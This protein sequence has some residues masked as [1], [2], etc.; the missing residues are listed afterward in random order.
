M[1][2]SVG[3]S[4]L[5]LGLTSPFEHK[6]KKGKMMKYGVISFTKNHL[7]KHATIH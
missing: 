7:G 4:W 1:Q 2:N 3:F 5:E 6:I